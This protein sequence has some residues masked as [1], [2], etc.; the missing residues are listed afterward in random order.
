MEMGR[1]GGNVV[2]R[3][4]CGHRGVI[5]QKKLLRYFMVHR[6]DQRVHLIAR[7][8]KCSRCGKRPQ[9]VGVSSRDPLGPAW[10]PQT[11]EDWKRLIK[12]LRG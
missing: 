5:D 10:G 6:W 7:R 12:R 1:H 11:E 4:A 9:R 3:C 2:A 8:L